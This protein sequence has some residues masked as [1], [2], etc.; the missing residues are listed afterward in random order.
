MAGAHVATLEAYRA[1]IVATHGPVP[2]VDPLDGGDRAT[3]LLLLETPSPRG[4]PVRFVSRDNAAGTARN[5]TRFCEAGGLAREQMV[6]WNVVPWIIHAEGERNRAP[7]R[8]EIAAGLALLPGLLALLPSLRVAVIAGRVA[9]QAAPT[10]EAAKP[11]VSVLSM[12]HPS[13]TYVNTAP[14]IAGRIVSVLAQAA[15]LV[16]AARLAQAD[17]SAPS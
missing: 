7:R 2:H 5:I 10:I 1:T 9:M 15:S 4:G 6:I 16:E 17:G 14:E 13:P 3:C 8:E 11:R 12:P